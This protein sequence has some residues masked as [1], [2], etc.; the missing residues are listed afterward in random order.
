MWSLV[1][2]IVYK[3]FS[4]FTDACSTTHPRMMKTVDSHLECI[5]PFFDQVSVSVANPTICFSNCF[6]IA[7]ADTADN[8]IQAFAFVWNQLI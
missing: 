1:V 7:E 3:L 4:P 2:I 6:G 5:K 8:W